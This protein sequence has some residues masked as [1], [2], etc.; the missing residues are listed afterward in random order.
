MLGLGIG[1]PL[2]VGGIGYGMYKN[3]KSWQKI[4]RILDRITNPKNKMRPGTAAKRYLKTKMEWYAY[5]DGLRAD[6]Y[7]DENLIYL[8]NKNRNKNIDKKDIKY[9]MSL[10]LNKVN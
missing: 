10:P 1:L 9:I 2:A 8:L 7:S 6:E 5:L 4:K 3:K